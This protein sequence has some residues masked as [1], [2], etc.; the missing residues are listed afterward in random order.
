MNIFQRLVFIVLF[1]ASF[2]QAT[3]A[4][5]MPVMSSNMTA[6]MAMESSDAT[7]DCSMMCDNDSMMSNCDN[8]Q[9][10]CGVD[11]NCGHGTCSSLYLISVNSL[12]LMPAQLSPFS[13]FRVVAIS[14]QT[15]LYRPPISA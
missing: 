5:M 15:S 14:A 11:C 10:D 1:V 4:A 3:A 9:S 6:S 12:V 13:D 7:L 8:M 2:S